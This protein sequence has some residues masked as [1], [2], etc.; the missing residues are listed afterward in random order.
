MSQVRFKSISPIL[1][2]KDI[3]RA[4]DHY[5]SL[6]FEV[7]SYEGGEQYGF[8]DRD[9]VGLHFV[10]ISDHEHE[11]GSTHEHEAHTAMTYLYVD[12]ADALATEWRA[13]GIAGMTRLPADTPYGLHEGSHVDPDGNL[14]RFGSPL[15]GR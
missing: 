2:V 13:P 4:L 5:A 7:N 1:P 10:E 3:G 14:I 9:E 8:A 6:G 11:D 12:D 15:P